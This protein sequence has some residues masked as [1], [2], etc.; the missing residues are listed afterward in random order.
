[1]LHATVLMDENLTPAQ[2]IV[3]GRITGLLNEDGYCWASNEY[4]ADSVATT[5]NAVSKIIKILED[6]DYIKIEYERSG[7]R[8]KRRKI[9][10]SVLYPRSPKRRRSI[11]QTAT[12]H[13]LNG[14]ESSTVE[15]NSR[16][17]ADFEDKTTD[18]LPGAY[19]KCLLH[20]LKNVDILRRE[21]PHIEDI[22]DQMEKWAY[23]STE[24]GHR[25]PATNSQAMKKIRGWL[26]NFKQEYQRPSPKAA[27]PPSK[28]K[29]FNPKR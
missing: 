12:V 18:E 15:I 19:R 13:R 28:F 21:Y 29:S 27:P 24:K 4:L 20:G 6:K 25:A 7:A 23:W 11:A 14:E 10:A 9:Y 22:E 26:G 5:P 8:I 3:L 1:M 16:D 17:A 2:K